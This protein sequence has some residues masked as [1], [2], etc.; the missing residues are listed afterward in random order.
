VS[1][2]A[3][4]VEVLSRWSGSAVSVRIVTAAEPPELIA[5]FAG[6]LLPMVEEKAPAL[7]WPLSQSHPP[8]AERPGIY[9]HPESLLRVEH[10]VGDSVLEFQHPGVVTN[11]RH[12]G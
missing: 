10:H 1:A 11:V 3:E 7:F 8:P 6:E 12:L 2:E 5:V 4:V 9:L